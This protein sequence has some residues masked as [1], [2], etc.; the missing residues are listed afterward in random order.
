MLQNAGALKLKFHVLTTFFQKNTLGSIGDCTA[1]VLQRSWVY[2][3]TAFLSWMKAVRRKR[4]IRLVSSEQRLLVMQRKLQGSFTFWRAWSALRSLR[5]SSVKRSCG[6]RATRLLRLV[7]MSWHEGAVAS[8]LRHAVIVSM[9]HEREKAA[10]RLCFRVWSGRSKRHILARRMAKRSEAA[11]LRS[12]LAE[13]ALWARPR[14][15]ISAIGRQLQRM[16]SYTSAARAFSDWRLFIYQRADAAEALSRTLL[17]R[18]CVTGWLAWRHWKIEALSAV[19]ARREVQTLNR[20]LRSLSQAVQRAAHIDALA[21][22]A[23]CRKRSRIISQVLGAWSSLLRQFHVDA[24]TMRSAVDRRKLH[25]MLRVWQR[26][27]SSMKA[28]GLLRQ[29]GDVRLVARVFASWAS[30]A[31]LSAKRRGTWPVLCRCEIQSCHS[32]ADVKYSHVKVWIILYA[33][34]CLTIIN[35]LFMVSLF[36]VSLLS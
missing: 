1:F 24:I 14:S 3:Q 12:S 31:V 33:M 8:K 2:T 18:R 13:W 19:L 7:V 22:E 25:A 17:I 29:R 27:A 30:E 23:C 34:P 36:M 35:Y 9:A 26:W 5:R 21:S 15:A 20:C 32:C 4:H 28:S 10:L 16:R 6:L 11:T